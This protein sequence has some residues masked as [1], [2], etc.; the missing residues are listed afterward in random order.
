MPVSLI[1]ITTS[2]RP[3]DQIRSMCRDLSNS[4]PNLIRVNRGKM[5]LDQVAEKALELEADRIFLV[6]RWNMGSGKISLLI[7]DSG[8][9]TIFPPVMFLSE[10]LLRRDFEKKIRCRA[11]VIT[12]ESKNLHK[13]EKLAKYLSKFF[14]LPLI[15]VDKEIN[16][17]QSSMH[18]SCNSQGYI[19]IRLMFLQGMIEIGP[20][21]TVSKLVWN[22][23]S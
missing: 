16:R 12:V 5:S 23:Q 3:T 13:I 2:R 14:G 9:L 19:Q 4:I 18:V 10:I 1:L 20:R 22:V 17:R 21:V 11:S 15:G 7:I 8:K 6:D